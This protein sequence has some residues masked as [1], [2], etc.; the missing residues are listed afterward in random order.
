MEGDRD[1]HRRSDRVSNFNPLPPHGGRLS[2]PHPSIFCRCHFNP[3]PP[4][5]GRLI[6]PPNSGRKSTISIHSL[7]MEGDLLQNGVMGLCG[8]SIHSL[9]MEG[10]RHWQTGHNITRQ[11]SIHSLRMEGDPGTPCKVVSS[12]AFQST[13]SAWRETQAVMVNMLWRVNFNPLPPHGGRH[14]NMIS[15][16]RYAIFQSTP[17]AWRETAI[18]LTN[19]EMITISIHSLRME[20]DTIRRRN[21]INCL[22]FQSTPSAWRETKSFV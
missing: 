20:G 10:D 19:T 4:H 7:R 8:I 16:Q 5:G 1:L 11:I 13:P 9:R 6:T 2:I 15:V 14:H 3:L 21:C 22:T 18:T 12:F 17:S